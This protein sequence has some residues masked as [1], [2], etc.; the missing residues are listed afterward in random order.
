MARFPLPTALL[1]RFPLQTASLLSASKYV[2]AATQECYPSE[3]LH[4]FPGQILSPP[5]YLFFFVVVVV[6]CIGV[7]SVF[8]SENLIYLGVYTEVGQ[9]RA[10]DPL[11]LES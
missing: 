4:A 8:M 6:M 2:P 5:L 3:N 10:L 9:K 7:F 1:T 11:E